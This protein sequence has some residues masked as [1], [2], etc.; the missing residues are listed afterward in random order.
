MTQKWPESHITG[1]GPENKTDLLITVE[2]TG[3]VSGVIQFE[4]TPTAHPV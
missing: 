3:R 4:L 2:D 1:V